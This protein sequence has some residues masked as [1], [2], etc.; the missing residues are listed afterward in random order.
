[1][2]CYAPRY[3]REFGCIAERCRHNC[4]I[5][6]EIG[7]DPE[8][9]KRYRRVGGE[10]GRRLADGICAGE[11]PCFRLTANERCVF[12]NDRNLCEIVRNL[13]EDALCQICADHPRFRNFFSD[14][15]E[16]GLG[17]CC[18]AAAELILS[19][20]NMVEWVCLSGETEEMTEEEAAFF[21]F[22]RQVLDLIQDRSRPMAERMRR[23][24][25][26]YELSHPD[27]GYGGWAEVL[28]HLERLDDGWDSRIAELAAIKEIP[29]TDDADREIAAEQLLTYFIYRHLAEGLYD[30]RVAERLS[31][32]VVSTE[33]ITALAAGKP[34]AFLAEVARAYSA[35]VEYSEANLETMFTL[36][37]GESPA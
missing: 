9:V 2:K 8:S 10:F 17:L 26:R 23:L 1:M 36:M 21:A 11:E 3:Y 32:A 6:W 37:S 22:R 27:L 16:L 7:I 30:G 5:G 20:K 29:P 28:R 33:L 18:E 13:G 14:R 4:C 12:L 24:C 15:E 35:E 19:Q 31:F 34:F 25:E